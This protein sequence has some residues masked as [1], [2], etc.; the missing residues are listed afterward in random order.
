MNDQSKIKLLTSKL[1]REMRQRFIVWPL[2]TLYFIFTTFWN[3]R[4]AFT[5]IDIIADSGVPS[6]AS[7]EVIRWAAIQGMIPIALSMVLVI[8]SLSMAA[9]CIMQ[10]IAP[11]TEAKLLLLI[12][13]SEHGR[14]EANKVPEDIVAKAPNPQH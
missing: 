11:R 8:F 12:L 10:L 13:N 7:A 1:K 5:H 2:L 9:Y 4:K 6:D 14:D 3:A